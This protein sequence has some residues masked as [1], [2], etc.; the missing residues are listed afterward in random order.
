LSSIRSAKRK[1]YEISVEES[2][3]LV[4]VAV[5]YVYLEKLILKNYVT[6]SNLKCIT[7]IC[8]LLAVK[9]YG[10]RTH[11]YLPLLKEMEDKFDSTP[12]EILQNEFKAYK[13]LGFSLL[14]HTHE[15]L[16]HLLKLQRE[17]QS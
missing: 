7:S 4:C 15:Y 11:N 10:Q 12:K 16:P 2:I 17:Y 1:L 3:D 8:L 14:T 6:K 9:F 5:A 13:T